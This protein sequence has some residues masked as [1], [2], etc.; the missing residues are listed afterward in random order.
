MSPPRR[1]DDAVAQRQR[2]DL[3]GVDIDRG[4]LGGVG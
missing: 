4:E 2:D 3:A 1:E